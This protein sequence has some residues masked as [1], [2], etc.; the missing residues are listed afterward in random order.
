MIFPIKPRYLRTMKCVQRFLDQEGICEFPMDPFAVIKRN[1]WTL[2]PYT[3]L[4]SRLNATIEE[5]VHEF[6]GDGYTSSNHRGCKIAYND[7][8]TSTERIRFTLMHEVAHIYL[9]HFSDFTETILFRNHIVDEKYDILEKEANCFARNCLAPAPIVRALKLETVRDLIAIF[10]ISRDAATVRL[11]TLDWDIKTHLIPLIIRTRGF[12]RDVLNRR[13]CLHCD[14]AFTSED[15]T[16]CPVCG[17]EHLIHRK[18]GDSML[19]NDGYELDLDGRAIRCPRCDNEEV[20][21]NFCKICGIEVVNHCTNI[22]NPWAVEDCGAIAA[23]NA[24]Y[25]TKCGSPTTFLQ[26]ELLRDW[27]QAKEELEEQLRA[28]MLDDIP[29]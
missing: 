27:R 13:H 29:F 15:A 26:K 22:D 20:E 4:A 14:Y 2:I 1:K 18:W 12:I 7:T 16:F 17:Q 5:I 24:R 23:G 3:T 9:G 11:Q 28:E 8:V 6:G 19:Y 21:D 10:R 25:C